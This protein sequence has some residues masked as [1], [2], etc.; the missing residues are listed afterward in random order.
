[1]TGTVCVDTFIA[2][3]QSHVVHIHILIFIQVALV[4]TVAFMPVIIRA[5]IDA[6]YKE[7]HLIPGER[8]P[9]VVKVALFTQ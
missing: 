7:R 1:M 5:P 8:C 6:L 9:S 4:H 3:S 2:H